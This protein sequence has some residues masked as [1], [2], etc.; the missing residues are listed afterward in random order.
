MNSPAGSASSSPDSQPSGIGAQASAAI[1]TFRSVGKW[2]ITSFA[3]VGTLL[4]AGVQLTSLGSASGARLA[5]AFAGLGIAVA[6]V[7]LAV[8][9]LTALLQPHVSAPDEAVATA[10][11]QASGLGKFVAKHRAV[12]LPAGVTT[13]GELLAAFMAA[14]R[15]PDKETPAGR[16]RIR[17][18]RGHLSDIVWW[19]S[20]EDA[21]QR[22]GKVRIAVVLAAVAVAAG[23]ALYSWAA[24]GPGAAA[25]AAGPVPAVQPA[26]V[27]VRV[28]LNAAGSRALTGVLGKACTA[29]AAGKGV[30]AIALSATPSQ[31][32]VV[33]IPGG[34]ACPVP[35]RFS[36]PLS[37][38]LAV[39]VASV[40]PAA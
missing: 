17:I 5:A 20:Y 23:V 6:A 12:L 2:L 38:G 30:P 13:A 22:F 14:R 7:I 8:V 9:S 4:L 18:L 31:T 27:A 26:P 3:A 28:R 21:K 19:A 11:D 16:E 25:T 36:L 24:T 33:L 35:V 10:D 37:Q 40:K 39:P 15:S 34:R 1:D 32:T 29:A